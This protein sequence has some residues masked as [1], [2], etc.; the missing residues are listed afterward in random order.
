MEV[1]PRRIVAIAA[2]EELR[3]V[4]GNPAVLGDGVAVVALQELER[5][6]LAC[7]PHGAPLRIG[8][9]PPTSCAAAIAA[10]GADACGLGKFGEPGSP[11]ASVV[12]ARIADD[13]GFG[14]LPERLGEARVS[15]VERGS[16]EFD[17]TFLDHASRPFA[18]TAAPLLLDGGLIEPQESGVQGRRHA[19]RPAGGAP[20]ESGKLCDRDQIEVE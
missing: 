4:R 6:P 5:Q 2:P 16:G 8:R 14:Q 20:A 12:P 10:S 15:R 11:P 9:S 7:E 1:V 17:A 13:A 3:A 19:G 18:L